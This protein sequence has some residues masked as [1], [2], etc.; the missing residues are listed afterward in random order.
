MPPFFSFLLLVSVVDTG[1][2][3]PVRL[4]VLRLVVFSAA[5]LFLWR[6]RDEK[7]EIE[8]YPLIVGG[9][10]LLSLGHAFSSIYPWVSMQHAL[11]IA[12]AS[13]ILGW[14]YRIVRNDPDRAREAVFLSVSAV[15]VLQFVVALYQRYAA[16]NIR[17]RGTFDN[18]N[19]FAEF[20]AVAGVLCLS[21]FLAKGERSGIRMTSAA[22]ADPLP[23]R[24]ACALR[25][26]GGA[27]RGGPGGG[28]TPLVAV[29]V[30]KGRG[31]PSG[32]RDSRPCAPRV[33]GSGALHIS[34]SV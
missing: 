29:R 9:F 16:G 2:F 24:R 3:F 28:D 30:E 23:R 13:V 32:R 14:A 33:P 18:T 11:N 27:H 25:I 21:R 22:G 34:G 7:S 10:A 6:D 5:I 4:G 17:P 8:L 26:P 12:M 1:K 31:V 20:M 19:F 15:A